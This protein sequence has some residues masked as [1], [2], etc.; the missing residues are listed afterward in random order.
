LARKLLPGKNEKNQIH[1]EKPAGG[2][3][4]RRTHKREDVGAGLD[5]TKGQAF[6]PASTA[7]SGNAGTEADGGKK[8][9][10]RWR[11]YLE[12]RA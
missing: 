9:L 3:K 5:E 1:L 8:G 4:R 7:S 11:P 2:R 12:N 10:K 6:G